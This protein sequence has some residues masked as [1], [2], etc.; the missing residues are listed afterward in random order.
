MNLSIKTLL[1]AALCGAAVPA[2]AADP[3]AMMVSDCW[4]RLL[5]GNLPSGG[6]FSVMNMSDKPVD[7]TGVK[8]D[9]FGMAMLHQ[10]QSNGSTSSMA[11]V[12]R[13]AVPAGGTLTF[14]PG[15]YHVMLEQPRKPLKVGATVP[16]TFVFGDGEKVVAQCAVKGAA[17][18]GK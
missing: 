10:T 2:L 14:S 4:I 13:V 9:A 12:D 7:L 16:M 6:Y 17:A 1:V 15:N 11:M 3:S 5:P 8:S 18:T